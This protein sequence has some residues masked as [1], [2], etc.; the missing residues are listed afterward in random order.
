MTLSEQIHGIAHVGIPVA[1]ADKAASSYERL[2]FSRLAGYLFPGTPR[3][4]IFMQARNGTVLELYESSRTG[5]FGLVDHVALAV[6][7]INA[8]YSAAVAEGWEILSSEIGRMDGE[9][10][11]ARYFNMRMPGGETVEINQKL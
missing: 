11:K 4:A 6:D 5:Y 2:G 8:A 10:W 1:D 7:D 3:R 9:E